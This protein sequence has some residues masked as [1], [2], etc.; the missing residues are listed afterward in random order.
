LPLQGIQTALPQ[1]KEEK[2]TAPDGLQGNA[3][4]PARVFQGSDSAAEIKDL[5]D[6]PAEA[7]HHGR[8]PLARC[9]SWKNR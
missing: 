9:F 2:D 1:G 4:P 6:I 5:L 3:G 7:I 8:L